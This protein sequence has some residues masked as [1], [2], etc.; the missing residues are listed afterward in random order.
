VEA[1]ARQYIGDVYAGSKVS[2][3]RK[4]VTRGQVDDPLT[5]GVHEFLK[6]LAAH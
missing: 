6:E 2:K 5:E 4:I 1:I 3:G